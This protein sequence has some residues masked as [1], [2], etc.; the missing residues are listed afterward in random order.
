MYPVIDS[1]SF[2]TSDKRHVCVNYEAPNIIRCHWPLCDDIPPTHIKLSQPTLLDYDY[3]RLTA[4]SG[5]IR[6]RCL[7]EAAKESADSVE[8]FFEI[9]RRLVP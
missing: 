3:I 7:S 8:A 6:N 4:L 2:V 9:L 5:L 1:V